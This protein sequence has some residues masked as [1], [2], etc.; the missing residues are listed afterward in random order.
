MILTRKE[1]EEIWSSITIIEQE[2]MYIKPN[3]PKINRHVKA[4]KKLIELGMKIK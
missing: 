4:I 1:L 2:L 3:R